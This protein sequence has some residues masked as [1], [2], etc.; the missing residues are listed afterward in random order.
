MFMCARGQNSRD[1]CLLHYISIIRMIFGEISE[2]MSRGM[3][4]DSNIPTLATKVKI[5]SERESTTK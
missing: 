5:N 3:I 1:F 4:S 2:T